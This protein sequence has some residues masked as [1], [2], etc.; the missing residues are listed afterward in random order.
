MDT[1]FALHGIDYLIMAVYFLF[2]PG[3]GC[4]IKSFVKNPAA[5]PGAEREIRQRA[6]G[7]SFTSTARC[8]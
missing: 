1:K 3:R 2:I 6:S 8:P 5:C 7:L 4:V